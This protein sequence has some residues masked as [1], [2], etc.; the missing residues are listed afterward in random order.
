[1]RNVRERITLDLY[2]V[3]FAIAQSDRVHSFATFTR[4]RQLISIIATQSADYPKACD[5]SRDFPRDAPLDTRDRQQRRNFANPL[6]DMD[7]R[8]F[9]AAGPSS[10]IYKDITAGLNPLTSR[11]RFRREPPAKAPLS[12]YG[13]LALY[14]AASRIR[15]KHRK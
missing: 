7:R 3:H 2:M 15:F 4:A 11:R 14:P 9:R 12:G 6:S 10:S 5:F 1:M 8:R 13:A